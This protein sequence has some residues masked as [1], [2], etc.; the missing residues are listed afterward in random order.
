MSSN[1]KTYLTLFLI[2]LLV[3]VINLISFKNGH[4]WGDDF[5][6]YIDQTRSI[7]DGTFDDFVSINEYRV[8]NSTKRT[9]PLF[10][11]WG[12]PFLLSPIY[13]TFGLDIH[14]MKVYVYLFFLFFLL[15]VFLLFKDSLSNRENLLLVAIIAFSTWFFDFKDSVS[16]DVPFSFFS[17]LSLYLINK[18]L[19]KNERW[20]NTFVSFS[21]IGIL[22]SF[23][24]TIKAAGIVLLPT[25]L[26]V[27]YIENRH[28]LRRN[29]NFFF[30]HS[31]PY[32]IFIVLTAIIS[33]SISIESSSDYFTY[34]SL[35]FNLKT[36]IINFKY[37]LFLPSR[38]FPFL[39]LKMSASW[40]EF[41]KFSLVI[42]GI[43]L[44]FVI[45][46]MIHKMKKD[47][48]YLVY[49]F[50]TLSLLLVYPSRNGARYIISI[51]PFFL[52]FLF[53]GLSKI[54]LSFSVTEKLKPFNISG[55]SL[56][57]V[58]MLLMS[59]IYVSHATYQ[60][61]IFN[62]TGV[63][64]GP[65]SADSVELFNYI[66]ANS[67]KDDAVIFD[68]PRAMSL[69]TN[70]KSLTLNR[71]FSTPDDVLNAPARYVALSKKKLLPNDF[72]IQDFQG[73]LHCEFENNTFILCELRKNLNRL[74][75]DEELVP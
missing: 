10:S 63:I 62:R 36:L 59:F 31:I 73:N 32:V 13:Y 12:L 7:V 23:T 58:S 67:E 2:I 68:K 9:G 53:A 8:E 35:S 66:K 46:G 6:A 29:N 51:F 50:L 3:F 41:N 71:Y 39:F 43:M 22:I 70:R 1:K 61:I 56:F 75:N 25:L 65:Y 11:T 30:L 64:E 15:I 17:L 45:L 42:Y 27:Q 5:A 24:Y 18:F 40:F 14:V 20:I 57:G 4:N 33:W 60:N 54:T 55:I 74:I 48:F 44:S 49:I 47:Y 28:S 38:F 52:Y 72:T 21:L 69:Y 37:Y 19:I 16:P 26:I 34:E